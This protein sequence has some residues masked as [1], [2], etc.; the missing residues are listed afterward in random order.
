[1]R[2]LKLWFPE[3]SET[4]DCS[5]QAENY[6]YSIVWFAVYCQYSSRINTDTTFIK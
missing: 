4:V 6:L 2:D 5:T 3:L 1:M